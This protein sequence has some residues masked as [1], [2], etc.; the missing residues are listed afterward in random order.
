MFS[1]LCSDLND[2]AKV[3]ANGGP[4]IHILMWSESK[5]GKDGLFRRGRG[6][7]GQQLQIE[8][9]SATEVLQTVKG[10]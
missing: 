1:S 7:S 3:Q 2:I 9:Q 8:G 5:A 6:D 4:G 10:Y